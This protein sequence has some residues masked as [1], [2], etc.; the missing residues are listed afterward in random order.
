MKRGRA[1]KFEVKNKDSS[2]EFLRILIDSNFDKY[3]AII[4]YCKII[5]ISNSPDDQEQPRFK[6]RRQDEIPKCW[7]NEK[8][9]ILIACKPLIEVEETEE[10]VP[11]GEES[12]S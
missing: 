6:D 3:F 5:D 9:K 10:K 1:T 8:V 11:A 4:T 7:S 12:N 2:P